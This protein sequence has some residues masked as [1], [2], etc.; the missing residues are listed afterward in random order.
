MFFFSLS[1]D[2]LRTVYLLYPWDLN[3]LQMPSPQLGPQ[4][5]ALLGF[6]HL[7]WEVSISSPLWTSSYAVDGATTQEWEW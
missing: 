3:S 4:A 5:V 6:I 2:F 1:A 7:V